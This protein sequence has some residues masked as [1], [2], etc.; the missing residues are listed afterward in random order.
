M[1]EQV[2]EVIKAQEKSI[3]EKDRL[4]EWIRQL[5][6]TQSIASRLIRDLY[7]EKKQFSAQ[8]R[9]L[10]QQNTQLHH[11]LEY[12]R[13]I[14]ERTINSFRNQVNTLENRE[15]IFT[16]VLNNQDQ[17]IPKLR[18]QEDFIYVEEDLIK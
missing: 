15:T 4:R 3:E 7:A 11:N 5:Q 18:R 17:V 2:R 8:I 13:M 12:E 9:E 1:P 16:A 6:T 14:N 10:E